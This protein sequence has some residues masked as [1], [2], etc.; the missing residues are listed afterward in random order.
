MKNIIILLLLLT[1]GTFVGAQTMDTV[2]IVKKARNFKPREHL[3]IMFEVL[4]TVDAS[5]RKITMSRSYYFD[6]QR[7]TVSSVRE[8]YNPKKP[9][10]GIQVIYSFAANKLTS[11]TV[12]PSKSTCR[13]CETQYSYSNDTLLSNQEN[14]YVTV[15]SATF[16]KQAHFFQSKL[17]HDLP[18][19]FFD[20]EVLVNGEKK[21]LRKSY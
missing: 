3:L 6:K 4:D 21:K 20:D 9:D 12:I 10:K 16:I 5:G 7:R 15:N 18:W 8:N 19:G 13:K 11:V 2:L 1:M 17:P 14:R